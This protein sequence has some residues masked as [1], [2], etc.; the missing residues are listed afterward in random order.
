MGGRTRLDRY[1]SLLAEAAS[2]RETEPIGM[3][4]TSPALP[5]R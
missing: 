3:K 4:A 2:I 5:A 1:C